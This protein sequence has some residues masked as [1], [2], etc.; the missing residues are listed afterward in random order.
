MSKYDHR[1]IECHDDDGPIYIRADKVIAVW[2]DDEPAR[3]S[4]IDLE[5]GGQYEVKESV[6]TIIDMLEEA[7]KND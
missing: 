5:G 2:R 1:F 4:W 7:L 6:G 3:N